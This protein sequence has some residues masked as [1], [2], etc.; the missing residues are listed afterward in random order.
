MKAKNIVGLLMMAT[1][2]FLVLYACN[3]LTVDN[4]LSPPTIGSPIYNCASIISYGGADR[5]AKIRIYVNGSKVKEF[6]TWMG[7]GEVVLPNELSAGDIVSAA[8]IIGNH[9]SVKTREP[10]TVTTIPPSKLVGGEKLRK[11]KIR[12]PLYECQSCVIVENIVE[13]ATVRLAQ[14]GTE[15]KDGI[16]PYSFIRLYVPE[17]VEGDGYDAWQEMCLKRKGYVSDHSDLEK[18]QARPH[19][20]PTPEIHEPI[21]I[22]SDACRVDNLFLGANVRIYADD[23]SGAVQVGGGVAIAGAVIYKIN[24]VFNEN[25]IYF[26][27]QYLCDLESPPSDKVP[28][29]KEVPAPVINAPICQGEIYVTV[30]NTVVLSTVKVF[31]NNVQVGQAAGNG[32]CVK[33]ALGD[34]TVLANGD[35]VTAQQ[36]VA[37][38]ASPISSQVIVT[39]GGAPPYDPAYWNDAATVNCNNCYNYGCNIKTNTYAQ[40]GYAHGATHSL[41]C[42]TVSAAAQ[43]DG[44]VPTNID[45]GCREC[46]HIVALVISPNKD[47]HWYRLDD[48]GRWSHKMDGYPCSDLDGSGNPITNPETADRKVYNGPDIVRD[49]SIFCGYFCVDKNNVVID[50]PYSCY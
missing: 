10:I 27:V 11:S 45:K 24:P 42:A 48:N 17:L 44:L 3:G 30:C 4:S 35:K 34:A 19:D 40:P 1:L 46:T 18:V 2:I 21:I 16:T 25:S 32:D 15:M 38:T 5:D 43:A 26:A 22:G 23:G 37:A 28:P 47:Y 31:V 29:E 8:Q 9:I 20:L 36:I 33:I 49:Y 39:T 7:W 14:N 41:T 13:G 50:G 12:A 6:N